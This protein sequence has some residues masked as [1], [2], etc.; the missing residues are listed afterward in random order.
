M[1]DTSV[2]ALMG[3]SI[4]ARPHTP[5][6]NMP[7][8]MIGSRIPGHGKSAIVQELARTL[9][10][11][12]QPSAVLAHNARPIFPPVEG[13]EGFQDEASRFSDTIAPLHSG[14]DEQHVAIVFDETLVGPVRIT[15]AVGGYRHRPG[16]AR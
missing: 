1:T 12:G 2:R 13:Y 15:A 9:A 11:T 10:A 5:R 7:S 16:P 8:M 14:R 6:T 4:P 3:R